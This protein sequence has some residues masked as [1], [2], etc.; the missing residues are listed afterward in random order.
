MQVRQL[1]S[2][3]PVPHLVLMKPV[4]HAP[5]KR[6]SFSTLRPLHN[7]GVA[8]LRGITATTNQGMEI[9]SNTEQSFWSTAEIQP[10]V[11]TMFKWMEALLN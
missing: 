2:L 1:V 5:W 8:S 10:L 9:E 6:E 7:A 4:F 3:I 11:M